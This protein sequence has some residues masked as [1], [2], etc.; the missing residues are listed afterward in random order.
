MGKRCSQH[1][2]Y[3]QLLTDGQKT[4]DKPIHLGHNYTQVDITGHTHFKTE[5]LERKRPTE[6]SQLVCKGMYFFEEHNSLILQKITFLQLSF[7]SKLI[8]INNI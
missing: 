4:E 5:S 1:I 6:L 2:P 7:S 3:K 8:Y